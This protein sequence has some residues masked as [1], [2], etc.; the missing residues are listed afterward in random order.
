MFI[1]ETVPSPNKLR[2]ERHGTEYPAD[3]TLMRK[4]T[5]M[6]LLRSLAAFDDRLAINM[7]LLMEL[8]LWLAG[9]GSRT[10]RSQF[11]VLDRGS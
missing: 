3:R 4:S 2:Q 10:H 6:P 9:W 8:L 11:T 5:N 7:A 1:V